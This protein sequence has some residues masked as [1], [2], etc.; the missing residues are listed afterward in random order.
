[1]PSILQKVHVLLQADMNGLIDQVAKTNSIKVVDEYVS[2]LEKNLDALIDSS[3]TVSGSVRNLK[4]KYEEFS[5]QAKN[6]K[7]RDID[8]MILRGKDDSWAVSATD[9]NNKV[10]L[11]QEYYEQR[12]AQEEQL[13]DLQAVQEHLKQ[14]LSYIQEV[15]DTI[16]PMIDNDEILSDVLLESLHTEADAENARIQSYLDERQKRLKR[17]VGIGRVELQLEERIRRLLGKTSSKDV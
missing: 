13:Q 11:A 5:A 16:Q 14:R 12:Q 1:M 15:R 6:E 8:V 4:R 7:R 2:Q 3:E 9:L 10:E 17:T